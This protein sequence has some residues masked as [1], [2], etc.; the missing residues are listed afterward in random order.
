[1]TTVIIGANGQLGAEL[2]LTRIGDGRVIGVTHLDVEIT[3]R[4]SVERALKAI[5][6]AHGEAMV[7][8]NAAAYNLV[9]ECEQNRD[10]AF[11]VNAAGAGNVAAVAAQIGATVVHFSTDY[12]FDGAKGEPYV[13][14]DAPHPIS[15]YGDSKLAGERAVRAANPHHYILRTSGLYGHAPPTGRGQNF[16]EMMLRRAEECR[17]G[18]GA[19]EAV[20]DQRLSPTCTRSLAQLLPKIIGR[21]PFGLYHVTNA[22][23]CSWFEFAQELFRLASLSVDLRPIS[24]AQLRRP[25]K[26]PANSVL[27]N[28]ALRA[29]GLDFMPPWR[30][31]LAEYLRGRKPATLPAAAGAGKPAT[32]GQAGFMRSPVGPC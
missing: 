32:G 31:A 23:G 10:K 28:A 24:S 2:M 26:R 20:S 30:E 14:T 22:G 6:P 15:V 3:D 1:M 16:A 29:L 19:V 7:I 13:E 12:V 11:A 4:H 25:A 5:A 27:E 18:G 8:V 9:D 17:S 21:A